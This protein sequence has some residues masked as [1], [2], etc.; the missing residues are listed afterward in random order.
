LPWWCPVLGPRH[1]LASGY[2]SAV[3]MRLV[4]REGDDREDE[5]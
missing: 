5:A 4:E 2:D 3:G 1:L